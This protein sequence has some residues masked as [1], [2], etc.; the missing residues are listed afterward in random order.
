RAVELLHV[1]AGGLREAAVIRGRGRVAGC[2]GESTAP[3]F[4]PS[5]LRAGKQPLLLAVLI[6]RGWGQL[7]RS[8]SSGGGGG[9]R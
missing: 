1:W 3:S 5:Q 2:H 7:F 8:G 6:H 4:Y 9:C